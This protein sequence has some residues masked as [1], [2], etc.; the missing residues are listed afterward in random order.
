LSQEER[1]RLTEEYRN[2]D[3][4][5]KPKVMY[6]GTAR[7]ITEFRPKQADAI[8][9]TED[10]NFAESFSGMSEDYMVKEYIEECDTEQTAE[11]VEKRLREAWQQKTLLN[12]LLTLYVAWICF[13]LL[14]VGLVI[15]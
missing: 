3:G 1:D 6:H 15:M 9:V 10:P 2:R 5:G 7:D 8:F 4:A 14:A 12:P 11:I 13:M